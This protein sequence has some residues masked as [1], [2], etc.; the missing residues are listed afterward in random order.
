M[1]VISGSLKGRIFESPKGHR[2]HP[3][4]DKMRGAIF[5]ALGDLSGITIVDFYSG[6]GA[7]SIEAISRGADKAIAVELDKT[8]ATTIHKNLENLGIKEKVAVYNSSVAGWSKRNQLRTYDVVILDPPYDALHMATLV[9]AFKHV[10]QEGVV[11]LSFPGHEEVLEMKGFKIIQ[12]KYYGDS[13]LTFYKP[14]AGR[15]Q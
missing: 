3:M 13:Q 15:K 10:S 9:K 8:A 6:S 4:S 12:S 2:T 7:I 1:R 14:L 5:N 11:I